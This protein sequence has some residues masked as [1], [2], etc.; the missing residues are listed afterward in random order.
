MDTINLKSVGGSWEGAKF[1]Y[2]AYVWE[3]I[4]KT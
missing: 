1:E 4:R 2:T 3:N